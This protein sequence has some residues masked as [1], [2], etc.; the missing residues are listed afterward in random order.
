GVDRIVR[1][2]VENPL[3]FLMRVTA[4][5]TLPSLYLWSQ[6]KDNP[7]Y[8]QLPQYD[9]DTYWHLFVGEHHFKWPK[10]WVEG[11]LFGALPERFFDYLTGRDPK[12]F[13]RW[14]PTA[15]GAVLPPMIPT[16]V[17]PLAENFANYSIYRDRPLVARGL[18]G[19]SGRYQ[20][21]P[22]SSLLA[23]RLGDIL[24]YPPAKIDN[25]IA[26][27]TGGMGVLTVQGI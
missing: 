9:K 27:W 3:G 10:P 12:A 25:L 16:A 18:E 21:T 15:I 11:V 19:V 6:N 14:L 13:D 1:A 26:G 22:Y 5:I 24:N 7:K 20:D 8:R 17:L 23:R 4:A 2:A